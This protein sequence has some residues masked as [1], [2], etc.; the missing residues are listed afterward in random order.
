MKNVIMIGCDLHDK[1]MLLKIAVNRDSSTQKM[2]GNTAVERIRMIEDLQ[3]LAQK[4]G[5]K[6]ILFAYEAS[7]LGYQLHD[8]LH[9]AGI[10]C[11]VL[12]PTKMPQSR[13]QKSSKTDAKDA[14]HILE[15]IRAHK[16]AGTRLPE[17]T[18]PKAQQRED[19]EVVR[20][21]EDLSRKQTR[22]K[23]QIRAL[24]KRNGI[25]KRAELGTSWT[26][27]WRAHLNQL[28]K[29]G[30]NP[31][32]QVALKTLVRQLENVSEEMA[33]CD[34]EVRKLAC[35]Q[36][37]RKQVKAL[38]GLAGVGVFTALTFLTEMGDLSR[39]KNRRQIGS[40]AGLAPTSHESGK[41]DDRKGHITR[42]GPSRLRKVLCQAVWARVRSDPQESACY[43]R[44]KAK[45]AG[46]SKIGI[47]AV[48]RRLAIRMW[49][50]A[51][52]AA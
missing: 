5:A 4:A 43:D 19:Q 13:K 15:L 26:K 46:K 37:H 14:E 31:G 44:I 52:A 12:A 23:A 2:V 33:F 30:L 3:L 20:A 50:T 51:K 48:M 1:N 36:R 38:T 45:N 7:G 18:V 34:T 40:Y 35:T 47:V 6:E 22:L 49:H 42:Q 25:E 29:K 39:F 9:A 17:V 41:I 16:L 32:A 21:R 28:C 11:R 10:D 24:L 27:K 8:E